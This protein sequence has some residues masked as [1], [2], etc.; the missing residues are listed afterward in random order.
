M[1]EIEEAINFLLKNDSENTSLLIFKEMIST[2]KQ[3]QKLI[4]TRR[5]LERLE[6]EYYKGRQK[7]TNRNIIK[8]MLNKKRR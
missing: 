5:Q 8:A 4:K 7:Y 1:K 3:I 2:D 6:E